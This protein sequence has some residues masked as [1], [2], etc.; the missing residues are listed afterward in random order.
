MLYVEKKTSQ[1]HPSL[2]QLQTALIAAK[3]DLPSRLTVDEQRAMTLIQ[4]M[5]TEYG[6]PL[7]FTSW[8]NDSV[9]NTFNLREVIGSYV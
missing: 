5:K 1:T 3:S 2:I 4:K 8:K 7:P 6:K 9:L